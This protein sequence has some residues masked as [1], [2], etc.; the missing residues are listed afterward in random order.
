VAN[1][2][3]THILDMEKFT[4]DGQPIMSDDISI[5]ISRYHHLHPEDELWAHIVAVIVGN[6]YTQKYK[7]S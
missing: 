4:L 7:R 2:S 6:N 3:N 1:M 5:M